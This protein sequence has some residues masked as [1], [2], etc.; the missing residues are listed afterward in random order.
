MQGENMLFGRIENAA[1]APASI[2]HQDAVKDGGAPNALS[3]LFALLFPALGVLVA[4]I[5]FCDPDTCWHLALGKWMFAHHSLPYSDPFSSN[6][7]DFVYVRSGLPLMQHEW[8]SDSLFYGV[9]TV[10]GARALLAATSLLSCL[11]L[12]ILPWFLMR[13][14]RVP[15]SV[16][17]AFV[18]L[19]CCASAFRLWVRPE[20]ISFLCMSALISVNDICL[21]AKSKKAVGLCVAAVGA[22]MLFWT[23]CHALFL[24]GVAYL[25]GFLVL[26]LVSRSRERLGRSLGLLTTAM[27]ATLCTPWGIALWQYIVRLVQSPISHANKENGPMRLA[28]L[29]NPTS[30][31]LIG[32]I[33]LFLILELAPLFTR[34]LELDEGQAGSLR[35]TAGP[36]SQAASAGFGAEAEKG[37]SG[38]GISRATLLGLDWASLAVG[39]AGACAAVMF[40]RLTPLALLVV[41]AAVAMHYYKRSGA[42]ASSS[43]ETC[44]WSAGCQPASVAKILAGAVVS[45]IACVVASYTLAAPVIPSPSHLF[46]PPYAAIEYLQ[47]HPPSGRMLNDSKFG[48]MVTW[49]WS[50]PPDIFIDGRFDSFDRS[51]VYDY[52]SMRTC[53][54]NWRALLDRYQIGWVF[55][56][57]QAPIVKELMET[58]GWTVKYTDASAVVL[59][60]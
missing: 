24:T 41:M 19:T 3:I 37:W 59:Q 50:D 27:L 47:Q 38:A 9:F 57:P 42:G 11:S 13:R 36:L 23:N 48:S 2:R 32:M 49:Y 17:M 14:N 56:P 6:V 58:P 40:R 18:I 35:S 52:N 4:C 46:S 60:R 28:E 33:G 5:G 7:H 54:G 10:G 44:E 55:F 15:T 12:A 53:H 30:W 16:A 39:M 20:A 31:P 29:A 25:C 43:R 8:L 21:Q 22:L 45:M 26:S 1:G 34:R 51:L